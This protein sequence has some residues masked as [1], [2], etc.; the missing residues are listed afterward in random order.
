MDTTPS[1]RDLIQENEELRQEN[2][3]AC[4]EINSLRRE[5]DN[6]TMIVGKL[7]RD[8]EFERSKR[9][10][11]DRSVSSLGSAGSDK[12]GRSNVENFKETGFKTKVSGNFFPIVEGPQ[13]GLYTK[14]DNGRFFRLSASQQLKKVPV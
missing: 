14:R 9:N 6:L 3:D 8:L 10:D 13:G 5:V 2:K 1:T 11:D 7:S 12:S 4:D